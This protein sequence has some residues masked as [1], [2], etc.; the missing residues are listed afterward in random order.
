MAGELDEMIAR[1][2]ALPRAVEEALPEAARELEKI[3]AGNIVAQRG[4][5]GEAW[6]KPKDPETSTVLRG[7]M[8]N[9]T[10]KAIGSVLL[11]R[12]DGVEARHHLGLIKGK[13]SR[14]LIPTKKIP[15]PMVEALRRVITRR[16][17][18]VANGK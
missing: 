9:V 12:V 4:P 10:V 8:K 15:G 3:I 18:A 11:A 14:K 16:L 13:V 1:L 2:R 5:D 17:K 6:E 7:A